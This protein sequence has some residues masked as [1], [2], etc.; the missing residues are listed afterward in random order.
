VAGVVL[1]PILFT[2]GQDVDDLLGVQ[3]LQWVALHREV[4]APAALALLLV[5]VTTHFVRKERV[6]VDQVAQLNEELRETSHRLGELEG[7]LQSAPDGGVTTHIHHFTTTALRTALVEQMI[8]SAKQSVEIVGVVNDMLG[9]VGEL[10][11]PDFLNRGGRLRA[12]FIDPNG[13]A[14]HARE[15]LEREHQARQIPRGSFARRT[16]DSISRLSEYR[17]LDVEVRVYERQPAVSLLLIDRKWALFH[18]YDVSSIG[19]DTPSFEVDARAGSASQAA[20][21]VG[22]LCSKFDTLWE[23]PT[24]SSWDWDGQ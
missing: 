21:H 2:P 19:I 1:L 3:A 23:L 11:I 24:S 8:A 18:Y 17:H 13:Q 10:T 15:S 7:L 20:A 22:H 5:G 9:Q 16:R 12:L 6:W 4:W 14:V